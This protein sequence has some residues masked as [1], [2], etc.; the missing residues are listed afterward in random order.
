MRAYRPGDC[1]HIALHCGEE[2]LVLDIDAIILTRSIDPSTMKVTFTLMSETPSKHAFAL[3]ETGVPP[4]TPV[5]GPTG[6]EADDAALTNSA[7]G[8]AQHLSTSGRAADGFVSFLDARPFAK[9][10]ASG[11][12]ADGDVVSFGATYA[13][14]PKIGFA[15]GG[16]APSAGSEIQVRADNLTTSGFTMKAVEVALT[17]GTTYTDTVDAAGGPGEP[18]RV[19]H[20]TQD[21]EPWDGKY[22]YRVSV[23]VPE[24]APGEPGILYVDIYARI[25][26]TWTVVSSSV[27]TA[28]GGYDV[29]VTPGA[30][31]QTA[32]YEF[33]ASVRPGSSAGATL[34]DLFSVKY[35]DGSVTETSLTTNTTIPWIAYLEQ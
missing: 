26:G 28:S 16:A 13:D 18:D 12:A 21:L 25:G 34:D 35:T 22:T 6:E 4:E 7:S 14:V 29:V 10:I 8:V 20:K 2:D 3:G 27:Y 23:T 9:I 17:P 33:G 15:P 11:S 5:L 30:I 32:D 19:M 1:L 31:A 24:L